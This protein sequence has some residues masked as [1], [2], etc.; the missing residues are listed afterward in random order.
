[1]STSEPDYQQLVRFV[2]W[3]DEERQRAQAQL[4]R[5]AAQVQ[6]LSSADGVRGQAV[7]AVEGD[8]R[9][10]RGV[11]QRMAHVEQ[12]VREVLEPVAAV[13][14]QIEALERTIQ[15]HVAMRD[16]ALERLQRQ[17]AELGQAADGLRLADAQLGERVAGV[18]EAAERLALQDRHMETV[19][20]EQERQREL[21]QLHQ[22]Q[23]Q[24]RF[25]EWDDQAS[26]WRRLVGEGQATAQLARQQV[27][28]LGAD[29]SETRA[30][31]Q[32]NADALAAQEEV[33][34]AGRA[35]QTTQ[36]H[37]IAAL[38][39]AL[40]SDRE[41][42]Q[43]LAG[44]VGAMPR[45]FEAAEARANDLADRVA[46]QREQGEQVLA[47]LRRLERQVADLEEQHR[48]AMRELRAQVDALGQTVVAL[49]HESA[50][51]AERLHRR[52][53]ELRQLEEHHRER[54]IVELEQQLQELQGHGQI[55][56][57]VEAT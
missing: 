5:L 33:V 39:A 51:L 50:G 8:V 48:V 49:S 41:F 32:R 10:L 3:L 4:E 15:Q 14:M 56:R 6:T 30:V 1:M 42:A 35:Q 17:L 47:T 26:E 54:Q 29:L 40:T 44:Q 27:Q 12:A 23:T 18:A 46:A 9:R 11:E 24:R 43:H 38:R 28:A 36:A 34:S 45:A 37:E 31:A 57:P 2:H 7:A 53:A 20:R 21:G 25:T 13:R 16:V 19:A 22:L 55:A 52:L